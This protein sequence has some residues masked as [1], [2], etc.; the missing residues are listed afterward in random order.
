MAS[1]P[2]EKATDPEERSQPALIAHRGFA[3]VYPE[4]TVAAAERATTGTPVGPDGHRAGADAIEIDVM[5]AAT[6]EV[7]VFHDTRPGRLTDAPPELADRRIWDLPYETLAD[8]EVLASGEPVPLLADVLAAIPPDVGVNVEFK[9]PGSSEVWVGQRP[10]GITFERHEEL[11]RSFALDVLSILDEFPHDALVSS[12]HEPAIAAVRAADP[13]VPV[14]FVFRDSIERGLA[15]ARRYDCETVH[16]PMGMIAGIPLFDHDA[17]ESDVD[18]VA[19][20]HDE[21]RE[22]NVWTVES[23]YQASQLRRA[24]VDGLIADYPGVLTYDPA[25]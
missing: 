2:R 17:Y 24:G 15:V 7:V 1:R 18:L 14:A 8:L 4:N 20:A 5:A 9:N 25:G 22:V 11:W 16:P 19:R 6:G 13:D 3:G 12:F 23:W 10:D 21:G